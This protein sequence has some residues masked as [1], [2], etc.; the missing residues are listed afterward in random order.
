MVDRI[1]KYT[2]GT[3]IVQLLL[4]AIAKLC[5][6]LPSVYSEVSKPIVLLGIEMVETRPQH[7]C[8]DAALDGQRS[9]MGGGVDAQ[10]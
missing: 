6:I 3:K 5:W 10:R 2:G 7:C 8:C 1:Y 4:L 9:A